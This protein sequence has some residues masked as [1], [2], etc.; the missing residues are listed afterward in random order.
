M[1]CSK[2][3]APKIS[4]DVDAGRF[5]KLAQRVEETLTK[6]VLFPEP[7][8]L[9]PNL[10]L[11][12]PLN[13]LGSAPNVQHVHFGILRSFQ[14]NSF[15]RTRPAVGICVQYTSEEGKAKLLEHN[16]KFTQGCKL[17]PQL[18]ETGGPLYGS[19]ACTHLNIAFRCIKN[20]TWSPIGNL[21]DL[22][23][24]DN[25][26]KEAVTSGHRWWILPET[27]LKERQMDISLWRNQDQNENQQIHE[28]EILLTIK[29]AA[30]GFLKTSSS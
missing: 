23:L 8:Q 20:G 4:E 17:L 3:E 25:T 14:K 21:Q 5:K 26:L 24:E 22:I 15:D 6:E 29:V 28:V 1:S 12:S 16:R 7:K 18:L 30:Q 19:L 13:R 9:E 11:V 10:V 2:F 27:V